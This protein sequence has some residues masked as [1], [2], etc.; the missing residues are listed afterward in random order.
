MKFTCYEPTTKGLKKG[1]KSNHRILFLDEHYVH[2]NYN[3]Q[4]YSF[5]DGDAFEWKPGMKKPDS[6]WKRYEEIESK[7]I[8]GFEN[9]SSYNLKSNKEQ[10]NRMFD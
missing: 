7:N 6:L 2:L 4:Q 3:E 8:T 9:I 1:L 10:I 5:Q